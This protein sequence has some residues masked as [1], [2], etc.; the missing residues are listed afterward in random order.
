MNANK[1]KIFPLCALFVLCGYPYS[2]ANA[3]DWPHWRG[4]DY[5]GI[6]N[7][8]DWSAT[9]P[10]GGPKVLWQT[11]LGIGFASMAVG[12]GRVYATGNVGD[13]DILY[14]FDAKTGSQIWKKSY[15]CPLLD[16][17]HEGGPCATPTVN[18]DAVYTFSK[19]G[20]ALRFNAETGEIVW[21]KN[22]CKE[23]GVKTPEWYFASSVLLVGDLVIFNAGTYGTALN[24]TDGRLVWQN[25][26]GAGGYATGV[27][28]S[29]AGRQ[30]IAMPVCRELVG[31]NPLTGAV[32]WK[33][34][35]K[36]SY[37]INA[38]DTIISGDR[39]FISSGYNKGCALYK[40][41]DDNL[42]VIW[43]N[44]AMRNQVNSSALWKG[45]L[46]GF[47]GQVG[48]GGKLA[49]VDFESGAVKWSQSGMGTGS[50]MLADGKLIILS[51]SGKLIVAE[52]SPQEFKQL[53]SAQILTGKCWTVPVLSNGRI[54]ARNA[55][56]RLVCL[57]VSGG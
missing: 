50:L 19:N 56:G 30:C 7:E 33:I 14:C 27:P 54:Y 43:Q 16:K 20:D 51:E 24:K 17:S 57:D 40:I 52:A 5:N 23:L 1:S 41:T 22:L 53:A 13:N 44:K 4:P 12:K 2:A 10:E 47:D 21:H 34:P 26:K 32:L 49:C 9:W 31:L 18:G 48:G 39:L 45:Y 15:P 55:A 38:A 42:T 6:S 8:T 36:T 25:G 3:A 35:W 37:D 46:Y 11:E 28:F 29:V